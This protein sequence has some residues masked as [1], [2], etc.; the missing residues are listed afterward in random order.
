[1]YARRR[2]VKLTH[3]IEGCGGHHRDQAVRIIGTIV[4]ALAIFTLHR[5]EGPAT[6][7]AESTRSSVRPV[8]H[9]DRTGARTSA[10]AD[11]RVEQRHD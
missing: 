5:G 8:H 6:A 2:V 10:R 9:G 11:E 4:V 3:S 1:L 7:V